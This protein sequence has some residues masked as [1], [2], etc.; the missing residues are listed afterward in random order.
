[1]IF[2][3][4]QIFAYNIM[5]SYFY[6]GTELP[7]RLAIFWMANR[8]TDVI[9]PLLA[10][11]LLRLRGYHGYEG[12]RW[13][14]LIEGLLTLVIGIWSIFMM[15]PSPTQTKSWW[16]PKG[17]VRRPIIDIEGQDEANIYLHH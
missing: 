11:G 6:K 15:A 9:A 2:L 12:W 1:V 5:Q 13:L 10:Y 17:W 7:F 14:F 4:E 16:R 3:A 8:L